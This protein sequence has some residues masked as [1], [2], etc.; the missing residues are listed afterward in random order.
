[1]LCVRVS[2]LLRRDLKLLA[3]SSGRSIQVVVTD[4][5]AAVCRQADM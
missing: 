4:A 5:L 1:M 2:P 3:A